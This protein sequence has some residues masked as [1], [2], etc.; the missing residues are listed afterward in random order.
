MA[1][2]AY[3]VCVTDLDVHKETFWYANSSTDK[4]R[5]IKA[6][7]WIVSVHTIDVYVPK[8][9]TEYFIKQNK[10]WLFYKML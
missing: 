2:L 8:F 3:T 5:K 7:A 6:R 1:I 4:V 9:R 10:K